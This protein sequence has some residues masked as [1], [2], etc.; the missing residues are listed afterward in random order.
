MDSSQVIES[1]SEIKYIARKTI[2]K[3]YKIIRYRYYIANKIMF[4]YLF[5]QYGHNGN[6]ISTNQL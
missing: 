5:W 6:F 2:I 4:R 1:Y 3:H